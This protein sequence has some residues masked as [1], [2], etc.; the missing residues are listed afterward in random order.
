MGAGGL[1]WV[2]AGRALRPVESI[3]A[4][5]ESIS[6]TTLDRRVP[7]PDSGD[8]VARLAETMNAM[9]DR[10]EDASVRQQRFVADASHELRSPVAAI[11]TELEVAQRTAT[12]E[13]WPAV[14]DRLLAEE[15]R[16]EAVITDLLLLATL[17]EGAPLPDAVE[18]DLAE[19]AREEARR[20]A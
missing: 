16:L 9:L 13:E 11:R 20:R 18:V 6:G 19:E 3:R 8:E 17:D 12:A 15:A 2:L 4:E 5:V 10:L 14:A 1:T 7:V